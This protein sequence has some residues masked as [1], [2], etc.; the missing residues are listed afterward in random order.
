MV[1]GVK[2]WRQSPVSRLYL[3]MMQE[4]ISK[5]TTIKDFA[6]A[7]QKDNKNYLSL[8]EIEA[9]LVMNSKLIF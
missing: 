2:A 4:A 5:G 9:I 3:K 6:L 1:T 8:E 7:S